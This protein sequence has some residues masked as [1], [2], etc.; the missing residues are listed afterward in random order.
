MGLFRLGWTQ[1][2]LCDKALGGFDGTQ[3]LS[4]V[5]ATVIWC[6]MVPIKDRPKTRKDLFNQNC[7]QNAG[8][9]PQFLSTYHFLGSSHD[10]ILEDPFTGDGCLDALAVFKFP[11][12]SWIS[13]ALI[14][15]P[16]FDS[17][18]FA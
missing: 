11:T 5:E 8:C 7:T 12:W 17:R 3:I 2:L 13:W 6:P 9:S 16:P 14:R 18:A 15:F 4:H 10:W 1:W